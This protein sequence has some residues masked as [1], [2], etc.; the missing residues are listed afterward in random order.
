MNENSPT[1]VSFTFSFHLNVFSRIFVYN[2]LR[3]SFSFLDRSSKL[4]NWFICPSEI[5]L[6]A[7]DV[8]M[9]SPHAIFAKDRILSSHTQFWGTRNVLNDLSSSSSWIYVKTSNL[10]SSTWRSRSNFSALEFWAIRYIIWLL[11][12]M[13]MRRYVSMDGKNIDSNVFVIIYRSGLY[14]KTTLET[15]DSFYSFY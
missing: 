13:L 4:L 14:E 11:Y 3:S 10:L 7:V 6:M 2:L 9:N 15:V 5:I 12:F 1:R 8:Q